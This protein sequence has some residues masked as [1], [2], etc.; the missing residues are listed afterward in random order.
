[1][2]PSNNITGY[3]KVHRAY[4]TATRFRDGYAFKAPHVRVPGGTW[5]LKSAKE[6]TVAPQPE[7]RGVVLSNTE[8]VAMD[9]VENL[10]PSAKEKQTTTWRDIV[11]PALIGCYGKLLT[12]SCGL[13]KL[14]DFKAK[15][16]RCSGC[17][18]GQTLT[19]LCLYFHH[20]LRMCNPLVLL[21]VSHTLS[22]YEERSVCTC[23]DTGYEDVQPASVAVQLLNV[24]LFP[25]APKRPSLAVDIDLLDFA[26]LLFLNIAP[27]TTGFT[28]AVDDF[29]VDRSAQTGTVVRNVFIFLL[30]CLMDIADWD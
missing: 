1:M 14:G 7:Q 3:Q 15:P 5:L 26:R 16:V 29:L 22:D 30:L 19:I 4:R 6:P 2:D 17:S 28:R 25:C 9:D 11:I 10:V 24:G 13:S 20:G 23:S 8:D 21:I 27:N 18:R 12:D